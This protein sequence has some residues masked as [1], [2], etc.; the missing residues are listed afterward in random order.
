MN[1]RKL[2]G[3][4]TASKR[5]ADGTRRRYYYAWRGGP[6]LKDENGTPLLPND[7]QFVV[8]YAAAHSERKKPPAGNLFSLMATFKSTTEYTSLADKTRKDYLR[9]LKL[10]ENE[11][12]TMPLAVV[13]D[14]RARGKFKEWRDGMADNPRTADYAWTVLARV[15]SVAKDRGLIAVNVCERGGRL[16]EADRAEQIW[17]DEY[18]KAFLAVAS[19]ELSDALVM[20]LWTGQ[21]QGT[22]INIAWSQYDG[23]HLRLL[24]NKQR[25]GKKKMRLLIP[26]G[27]PLKEL[28]DS[29]RPEKAEGPILRNSFGE[30]WT[31]DGFR[32]SWG[33]AFDR[34]K[35]GDVDLHFHDLRGTAVTRL[36]LSG[37]TVP[38]IAAI[39]GH[40]PRD[41]DEILK[42]HYL[43]GQAEL[44]EQAHV[45]LVAAYGT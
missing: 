18:I 11:F 34:A 28:L 36:A 5:L 43:G 20:A 30:P 9:F 6:M 1:R 8:A 2:P 27:G 40:S 32:A 25:R 14:R 7:P 16:Y 29:R 38:Q 23:K 13:Q 39:T 19:K 3:V 31:S 22:L 15:L 10:I 26:V 44:A 41:V 37:C 45:K 4:A 17:L 33:K 35:L 12:G 42:A 21:R 24:P